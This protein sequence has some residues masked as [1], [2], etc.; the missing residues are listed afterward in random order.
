METS[1]SA[2]L[3]KQ[4]YQSKL[5]LFTTKTLRDMLGAKVSQAAFFSMLARLMRQNILQKLERD[6]Y[7]LAGR[8]VHD[9]RIANFLYEPSYVSLEAALNFHGVLSQFPYE[10][11][12][13]T[14]R[15]P[16]TKTVDEKTYRYARIKRPLFWGYESIQ[17]FLIA[18][19]EKALLDLLY[20][21][22]KGLAIVHT[23]E[24][25]TS[26]L[27]KARFALYAKEFPTMNGMDI[28]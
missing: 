12:S 26:K 25:D 7:M 6:K 14:T 20:L 17:G 8:R 9:F 15:K 18:Q 2:V 10:V 22:S 24:L 13:M 11:A 1:N 27:D 28:L 5:E 19:P 16:V 4:I 3:V 21:T 23:D